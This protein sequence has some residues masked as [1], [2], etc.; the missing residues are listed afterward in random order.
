MK[1]GEDLVW[2][3]KRWAKAKSKD[4]DFLSI[5]LIN[6]ECPNCKAFVNRWVLG[7]CLFS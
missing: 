6:F 2:G 5:S 3:D 1:V 7:P 4:E